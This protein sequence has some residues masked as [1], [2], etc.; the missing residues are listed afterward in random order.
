MQKINVFFDNQVYA[1]MAEYRKELVRVM[2]G[3]R[4]KLAP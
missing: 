2:T 4:G 3:A 1:V